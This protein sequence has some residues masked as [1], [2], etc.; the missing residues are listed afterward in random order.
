MPFFGQARIRYPAGAAAVRPPA[1]A[2]IVVLAGW[3]AGCSGLRAVVEIFDPGPIVSPLPLPSPSPEQEA[4]AVAADPYA[5]VELRVA[6]IGRLPDHRTQRIAAVLIRLTDEDQPATVR[7]AAF[8]ALARL[9][10]VLDLGDDVVKWRQ[11]WARHRDLA[12]HE[13]QMRLIDH[14]ARRALELR[15]QQQ[16]MQDKLVEVQRQ[17]YRAMPPADRP[18]ALVAMLGDRLEATRNLAMDLMGQRLVEPEQVGPELRQA[19]MARL[20][21]PS[22]PIR[23]RATLLLRDLSDEAAADAV[24]R[25]LVIGAEQDRSVLRA[26]L[27]LLARIPRRPAVDEALRFLGDP[28]LRDGAAAVLAAAADDHML[29]DEQASVALKMVRQ[30]LRGDRLPRPQVVALLGRIGDDRDWRRIAGW[31]DSDNDAVRESAAQTWARSS[32]SLQPLAE[33][34]GD[35]V[36]QPIVIVAATQRGNR[37]D[38]LLALIE[39]K[40]AQQQAAESWQRAVVAMAARVPPTAAIVAQRKLAQRD[41]PLAL[42][43]QLLTATIDAIAPGGGAARVHAHSKILADLL[44]TRAA[45]RFDDGDPQAALD[46]YKRLATLPTL[47]PDQQQ[48]YHHDLLR[49]RLEVGAIDEAFALAEQVLKADDRPPQSSDTARQIAA[50]F[51]HAADRS[52]AAGQL[53]QTRQVLKGLDV[54]FNGALPNELADQVTDLQTRLNLAASPPGPVGDGAAPSSTATANT[55]TDTGTDILDEP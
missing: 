1:V 21:D 50:L 16:W 22:P 54:L 26:Y 28:E 11:W 10:G 36:I 49:A 3:S 24:A 12:E 19:L 27:L 43:D 52:L 44:L 30:Q 51:L 14:F 20:D 7:A 17:L 15:E 35:P 45:V 6:A 13:W 47:E 25:R 4:A 38:T 23:R 5:L 2:V 31:L 42:R 41:E 9:S 48:R 33:R 18:E 46:D 40:P 53:K 29:N 8:D 37:G 55:G 39:H 34:A 32:R